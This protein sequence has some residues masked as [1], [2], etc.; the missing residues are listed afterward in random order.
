MRYPGQNY[1][2]YLR[3]ILSIE[4]KVFNSRRLS[5]NFEPNRIGTTHIGEVPDLWKPYREAK[6]EVAK[7][8]NDY[9]IISD[10]DSFDKGGGHV[11]YLELYS[12]RKMLDA[13]RTEKPEE[14]AFA[15]E[16]EEAGYLDCYVF[17]SMY[18]FD[19]YDQYAHWAKGNHDR[20]KYYI[21]TYLEVYP[22]K[23]EE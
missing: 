3:E 4:N 5:R 16:M 18:H 9:G 19:F 17:W 14:L 2:N 13:H 12:W 23:K 21:E 10:D 11:D 15:Y 22:P 6:S 7:K 1:K 20:I 8:C